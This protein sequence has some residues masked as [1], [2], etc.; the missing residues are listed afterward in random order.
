MISSFVTRTAAMSVLA[1]LVL[2]PAS[3][4]TSPSHSPDLHTPLLIVL[5]DDGAK[6]VVEV[7][8][9]TT[10]NIDM[11]MHRLEDERVLKALKTAAKR[12]VKVRV[13]LEKN[14]KSLGRTKKDAE[15]RIREAGAFVQWA[16]PEFESTYQNS[17]IV[18]S[19]FAYVS[20]CDFAKGFAE[21]TRAFVVRVLDPRD[22]SEMARIFEADWSRH[23]AQPASKSLAWAPHLVRTR[24][25]KIIDGA[26]HTLLIYSDSIR[27]DHVVRQIARAVD[28]GVTV[29]VLAAQ[30][31]YSA[32]F[33]WLTKLMHAGAWVRVMKRPRLKATAVLTDVGQKHQEALIGSI[34]LSTAALDESRGLAVITHDPKVL[35]RLKE[36]FMKD[37]ASAK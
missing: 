3:A 33:P 12:G 31:S 26:R 20:T 7:I 17:F 16:N 21:G 10:K 25:F 22:V 36:T 8:G 15:K 19:S 34:A 11:V 4:L 37:Y 27:D 6:P 30:D 18:D 5:P 35:K 23:R 13:M 2:V 29:R 9:G 32:D 28:R 14:P 1:A 24:L